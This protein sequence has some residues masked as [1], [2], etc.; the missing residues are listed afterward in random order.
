MSTFTARKGP[1]LWK[2]HFSGIWSLCFFEWDTDFW[3]HLPAVSRWGSQIQTIHQCH[4]LKHLNIPTHHTLPSQ[5][6]YG[7]SMHQVQHYLL[8]YPAR[9]NSF[10]KAT[11]YSW[12]KIVCV[13]HFQTDCSINLNQYKTG[14]V[15]RLFLDGG[16]LPTLC[17]ITANEGHVGIL[18][19]SCVFLL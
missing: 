5:N 18:I 17:G 12:Q 11:C 19:I 2:A 8:G 6:T 1:I 9:I 16:A 4:W 10:L 3:Q 14:L 15:G 7:V 13:N